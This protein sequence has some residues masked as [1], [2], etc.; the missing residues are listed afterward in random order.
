M[1]FLYALCEPGTMTRVRYI[2]KA[3][4]P[5]RRVREHMWADAMRLNSHRTAWLKSLLA[6]GLKPE[7]MILAEVREE[8]WQEAERL[9][10]AGFREMGYDLTNITDGGEGLSD[11]TGE[12][13]KKISAGVRARGYRHSEEYKRNLSARMIGNNFSVGVESPRF[14]GHK[15]SE[16]SRLQMSEASAGHRKSET[17]RQNI[18]KALKGRPGHVPWNKGMKNGHLP[19]TDG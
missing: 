13:A 3:N 8:A 4:N 6:R 5:R 10:I 16:A 12:I 18:A 7:L 9:L 17:H 19:D 11:P 2:G 1:T 15:H 14:A